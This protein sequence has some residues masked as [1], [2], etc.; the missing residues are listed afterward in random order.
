METITIVFTK[1]MWNPLS[2]LIRYVLP[3]SRFALAMSSHCYI[4]CGVLF[5]E[6]DPF[7]GVRVIDKKSVLTYNTVVKTIVYTV[8][9]A[10]AG[11][12]FLNKQLG[13]KYDFKGALGLGLAPDR[14]WHED[15]SWFCY[16]LA[17]A[18]LRAAG[19]ESFDN[20]CHV[21]EIALMSI[22]PTK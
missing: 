15:N 12:D 9:D 1:A 14:K 11:I 17:A 3:R 2:W 19:R 5:Y 21:T 6:A 13:K 18:T 7:T 4:D 10:G 22:F 8:H 20:L 16:E